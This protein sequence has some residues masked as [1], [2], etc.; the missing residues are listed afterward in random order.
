MAG[1]KGRS[2]GRNARS[3]AFHVLHGTFRD[4]RHADQEFI[5]PPKGTPAIPRGLAGA[6]RAE[7]NRMV[8]RMETSKT[9]ST[10]DDAAL[11]Q[12]TQLFA[13]T[14]AIRVDNVELKKLAKQLKHAVL[15]GKLEG[16]ELVEAIGKI[17]VL[18]QL[19]QKQSTQLRQGHMAIRQYLVEFGMTPSAR[20]RVKVPKGQLPTSNPLDKFLKKKA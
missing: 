20:N 11:Y 2:G 7:W 13:E 3:R 5:D 1:V 18:H 15:N 17:V 12:Y 9:L 6:A 4:D 14:E 19:A 10:V 8:A 16:A